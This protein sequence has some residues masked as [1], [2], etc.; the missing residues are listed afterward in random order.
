MYL[1]IFGALINIPLSIF[2]V[3]LL[4]SSTG[5]I[6]STLLC[7]LPLLIIMPIQSNKIIKNLEKESLKK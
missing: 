3:R 1:Y 7:F 5:V 4:G 6:M 2:L